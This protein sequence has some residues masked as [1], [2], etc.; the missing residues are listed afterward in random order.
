MTSAELKQFYEKLYFQEVET[1]DKIHGRLQLPLTLLLAIAGAVVFLFQNFEYQTGVWTAQRIAFVF[2]FSSGSVILACAMTW[3]VKALYNNEYY[4][5]PDSKKTAEY[6]A[7]LEETYKDY[8][9]RYKLVSDALDEYLTDYYIDYAT[10]NTQVN[11]RRSVYIHLC[12]GA[13][14][15]AAVLFIAAYLMFYFGDLDKGKIKPATEVFITK[16]IDVR[17]HGTGK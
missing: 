1:R 3:F 4:F 6:K 2:F 10:F 5:L 11:D 9:E 16:P 8:D 7:L 13:I 12:N 17:I 15:G 14:I